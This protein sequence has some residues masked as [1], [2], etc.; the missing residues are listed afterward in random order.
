MIAQDNPTPRDLQATIRDRLTADGWFAEHGVEII[1]QDEGEICAIVAQQTTQLENVTLII[2]V[3]QLEM[4]QPGWIVHLQLIISEQV[5]TNREKAN[6]ATAM[7][8]AVRAALTIDDE[9]FHVDRITQSMDQASG[10]FQ[11]AVD[12]RY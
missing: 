2:A 7:D 4:D 6:Y 11:T 9:D 8:V 5:T 12:F 1:L 10:L 3:S